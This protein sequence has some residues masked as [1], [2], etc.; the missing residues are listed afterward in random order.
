MSPTH[1]LDTSVLVELERG[2]AGLDDQMRWAV[3]AMTIAELSRG[4]LR[5][6]RPAR[7]ASRIATLELAMSR[8]ILP[9]DGT[10]ARTLAELIAWAEDEGTRPA[11][12]DAIIAATAATHGLMLVSLDRGFAPLRGFEGLDLLLLG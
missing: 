11:L 7:L 2:S 1:L 9:L 8:L 10:C 3:S 12:A 6:G 5:G 4:V